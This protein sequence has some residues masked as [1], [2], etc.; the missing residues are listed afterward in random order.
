MNAPR[1][2]QFY[3]TP[4]H[5]CPYLPG[6]E[7][8]SLF[9]DPACTDATLYNRLARL[10]FRRSG[11]HVYRPACTHCQACIPVRIPVADFQPRRRDRRCLERNADLQVQRVEASFSEE[12]Y[13]L[14][15]TYLRAR[16]PGGGM[17]KPTAEQ[18]SQFLIGSWS[19][20]GFLQ[21]RLD[22]QLISVAVID[23]LEDGLSAVYTFY[24][25]AQTG[26]SLGHYS[27]LR[28]IEAAQSM[29]LPYLYLGY[30]IEA[31]QKMAYKGTYRPLETLRGEQWERL[32]YST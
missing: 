25:P 20:T 24:D 26:R 23:R 13:R 4:P 22:R 16:H 17:D 18:F 14:Y 31:C 32:P 6:Q 3:A 10:G 29:G 7:S 9:A 11:G 27:I 2:V 21:L 1:Q 15:C 12:A 19:D 8:I 28:Q 30:W 5:P